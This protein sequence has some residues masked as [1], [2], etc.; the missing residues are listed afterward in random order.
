MPVYQRFRFVGEAAPNLWFLR[1]GLG[2]AVIVETEVRDR[3]D[4][5][6]R[7]VE[8]PRHL[9]QAL[10]LER[11]RGRVDAR[12]GRGVER[13]AAAGRSRGDAADLSERAERCRLQLDGQ[14][15]S[16]IRYDGDIGARE[17]LV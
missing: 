17:R 7:F 14:V 12:G 3:R 9:R 10:V 1:Q 8:N 16:P 6:G 13:A 5:A 2:R 11:L 15:D 4:D